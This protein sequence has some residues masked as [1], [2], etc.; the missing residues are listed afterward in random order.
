MMDFPTN[1]EPFKLNSVTF[2]VVQCF[3]KDEGFTL[4][5]HVTKGFTTWCLV[6]ADD[7][8]NKIKDAFDFRAVLMEVV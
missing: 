3:R 4:L 1:R 7:A 5:A 8:V 6:V 2:Y